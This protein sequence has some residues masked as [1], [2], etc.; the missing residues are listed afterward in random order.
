MDRLHPAIV[1]EFHDDDI[2]RKKYCHLGI[3]VISIEIRDWSII[4]L[5][6]GA[7]HFI[8]FISTFHHVE[9]VLL[10]PAKVS[11]LCIFLSTF[12]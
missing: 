1:L 12:E 5:N 7:I 10:Q 6:F 8:G 2:N 9:L 4:K 11:I 3:W